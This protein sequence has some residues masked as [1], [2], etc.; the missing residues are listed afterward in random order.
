MFTG[1]IEEV[2]KISNIKKLKSGEYLL[3]VNCKKIIPARL[4]IGDSI[5]VNGVCLTVTKKGKIFFE[6]LASKETLSRT[7]LEKKISN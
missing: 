6:T 7:N 1:I 3:S 5:A 4:S 2:G